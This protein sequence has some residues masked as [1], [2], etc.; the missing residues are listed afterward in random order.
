MK[1]PRLAAECAQPDLPVTKNLR[2][3][4]LLLLLAA[5]AGN[6]DSPEAITA[7][8]RD[9]VAA[10]QE[11]RGRMM[12]WIRAGKTPT[13]D[14]GVGAEMVALDQQHTLRLK[15][16]VAKHGWPDAKRFSPE[17]AGAAWLIAQHAD[18]DRGFQS[19]VLDLMTPMVGSG[20]ADSQNYALLFDRVRV[21]EGRPQRYG[22]QYLALPID[23]RIHFGPSTPIE[24]LG[25]LDTRRRVMGLP[26]HREYVATVR[27]AMNVPE[28]APPL[29]ENR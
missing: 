18:H 7:E 9:M 14:S 21:G 3:A 16:I 1:V 2:P 24:D 20:G 13:L 11:V 17:A 8:L 22:T 6:P 25:G 5:C 23:G 4:A 26:P 15:E 28:D 12:E 29:P 10:D 19:A 27:K